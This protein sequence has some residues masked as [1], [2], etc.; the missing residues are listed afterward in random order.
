MEDK[1]KKRKDEF[2][3]E[4]PEDDEEHIEYLDEELE[5]D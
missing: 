1:H 3:D 5:E 2:L 4:T